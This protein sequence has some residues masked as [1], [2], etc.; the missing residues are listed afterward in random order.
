M[1]T[2]RQTDRQTERT[3]TVPLAHAPRVN[4]Q[5]S[6]L[7]QMADAVH[8]LVQIQLSLI[9]PYISMEKLYTIGGCKCALHLR[10]V[11]L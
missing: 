4:K 7:V 1:V 8:Y 3:T 6:K 2:D 9:A 10:C 5:K 11:D